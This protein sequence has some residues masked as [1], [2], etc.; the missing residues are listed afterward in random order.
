MLPDPKTPVHPSAQAFTSQTLWPLLPS[1]H[2]WLLVWGITPSAATLCLARG[3]DHAALLSALGNAATLVAAGGIAAFYL[4][5][6]ASRGWRGDELPALAPAESWE[7]DAFGEGG[8]AGVPLPLVALAC[9][10]S[11]FL[12]HFTLPAVEAAMTTPR[13]AM[14]A[15][16]RGFGAA[17]VT[18]LAFGALGAVAGGVAAPREA[19]ASMRGVPA[20][21][22]RV[23][24]AVDALTTA[25][26]LVRPGLLVAESWW[27]RSTAE[28]LA[29]RGAGVL[30]C[31]FV[32]AAAAA[33]AAESSSRL[34]TALPLFTGAAAL[35][36]SLLLPCMLLLMGADSDG[37]PLVRTS[38]LERSAAG[39]IAAMG[40]GA[41]LFGAMATAGSIVDVPFPFNGPPAPPPLAEY[42]YDAL[43]LRY[44]FTRASASTDEAMEAVPGAGPGGGGNQSAQ[45][46]NSW[47]RTYANVNN[48][49]ATDMAANNAN[50]AGGG[51]N[52]AGNW[53]AGGG[54]GNWTAGGGGGGGVD[55]WAPGGGAA[56]TGGAAGVDPWARG[57]GAGGGAAGAATGG[58]DPWA[59]GGGV[60]GGGGAGGAAPAGSDGAAPA[61]SDGAAAAS[62]GA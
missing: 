32:V 14:E 52:N 7:A 39:T 4:M 27:E 56:A 34:A 13:R 49:S 41:V 50:N 29:T 37:S 38:L 62:D 51:G 3:M 53:T 61:A 8:A 58:R 19:Y 10:A 22:L 36:C 40:C 11:G 12:V 47:N 43:P 48:T 23:A 5:Q 21:L 42:D 45:W 20:L 18:L 16:G 60:G 15:V 35:A 2:L 55:P 25:P 33:A 59:P 57:G 46:Q 24:V 26:V 31:V 1:Q 28:R 6:L 30:R 9:S 17:A 44:A 54:G